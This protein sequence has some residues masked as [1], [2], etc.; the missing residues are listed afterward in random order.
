M[1][2]TEYNNIADTSIPWYCPHC[3][4][5]N[6]AT[7]IYDIPTHPE[8]DCHSSMNSSGMINSS[9]VD[10]RVTI[11]YHHRSTRRLLI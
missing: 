7:I 8:D 5:L 11:S 6:R 9:K 10:I 3:D 1:N 2:S 4:S